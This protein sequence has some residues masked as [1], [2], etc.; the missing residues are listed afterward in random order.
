MLAKL[1]E[2][3]GLVDVVGILF[4]YFFMVFSVTFNNISA[5]LWWSVLL[6]EKTTYLSQV[7]DKRGRYRII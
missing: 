3:G 5:I 2:F 4:V 6:V 1:E 7:A